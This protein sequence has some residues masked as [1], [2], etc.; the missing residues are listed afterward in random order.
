MN[1]LFD[2]ETG[3][4]D[5][6][7]TL[8]FLTSHPKIKLRAVTVTPGSNAQIGIVRHI[9]KLTGFEHIPVGSFKMGYEKNCVSSFHYQWLGK[10]GESEPDNEGYKIISQTIAQY[11]DLTILTGAALKNFGQLDKA[12]KIK[13]WVAQGGFAGDNIVP[14]EYRLTKFE[15]K[16]TC[17]TYN[18]N[19]APNEANK[20]LFEMT[21]ETR[22]LVSKNVCHGVVYDA[23]LHQ[24]I[25]AVKNKSKGLNLIYQGMGQYLLKNQQGKKLHDPLAA[26]VAIDK[27][28]CQFKEVEM[29]R[30]KGE[31]GA[32]LKEGTNT[33]ISISVHEEKFAHVFTTV[34]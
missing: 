7:M 23:A 11:P 1:L 6:V 2:M 12:I 8:C 17:P 27:D 4:P 26:C 33:F 13:R 18:F 30:Q 24:K 3:D 9:L 25:E 19:G 21:I 22:Y 5:D 31:W 14:P 32:N 20:M 28:I 34:E 29:Y 10:I 16:M 15:G